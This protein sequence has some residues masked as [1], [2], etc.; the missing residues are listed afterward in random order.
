LRSELAERPELGEAQ[1]VANVAG[2]YGSPEDVAAIYRDTEAKVSAALRTPPAPPRRSVLGRFFGVAA[3]PRTYAALIYLLLS[4]ATGVLYFTVAVTG[5]SLSLGL[6]ILIVGVPFVILF[7]GIVRVLSLVEGRLVETMLGVRMP[8][9]PLYADRGK[10]ILERVKELFTDPRS[11]STL[12]YMV[13]MLPL[14]VAYFTFATIGLSLS[15]GFMAAPIAALFG[16]GAYVSLD[17]L[18]YDGPPPAVL[19]PLMFVAGLLLLFALL[20]AARGIGR[21]HGGLA[22]HLLVKSAQY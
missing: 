20:H 21:L 5:V 19:L 4:V 2:S 11:W 13:L 18:H 10:P 9:R 7:L 3:D 17:G 16:G 6:A 12:L 8:R 1:V 14:G 22:K 15:F